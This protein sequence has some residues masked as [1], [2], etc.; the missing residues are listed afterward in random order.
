MVLFFGLVFSVGPPG[1]IS[2][3]A[4][5]RVLQQA[6]VASGVATEGGMELLTSPLCRKCDVIFSYIY[7]NTTKLVIYLVRLD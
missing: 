3:D 6:P 4:L 7:T 2:A 5:G 1:N